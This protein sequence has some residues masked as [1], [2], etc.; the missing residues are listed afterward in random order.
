MNATV[1]RAVSK[2]I[3]STYHF[4]SIKV[5]TSDEENREDS[6]RRHIE[7]PFAEEPKPTE[8]RRTIYELDSY[9]A[10]NISIFEDY[11]G[12]ETSE[13]QFDEPRKFRYSEASVRMQRCDSFF[14]P[15][16]LNFHLFRVESEFN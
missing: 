7:F 10:S 3:V 1:I 13:T 9:A 6:G 11:E 4:R 5:P 15:E 2:I 16:S 8:R 14:F 12:G